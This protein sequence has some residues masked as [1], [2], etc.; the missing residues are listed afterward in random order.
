[1]SAAAAAAPGRYQL[2]NRQIISR[3]KKMILFK[4]RSFPSGFGSMYFLIVAN[5]ADQPARNA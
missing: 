1:L 3:A 5:A 2:T 4:K